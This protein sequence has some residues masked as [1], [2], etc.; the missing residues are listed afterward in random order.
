MK[1][2]VVYKKD[3]KVILQCPLSRKWTIPATIVSPTNHKDSYHVVTRDGTNRAFVRHRS[4]ISIDRAE[5]QA[6]IDTSNVLGAKDNFS[7]PPVIHN[8]IQEPGVM[9]KSNMPNLSPVSDNLNLTDNGLNSRQG[10]FLNTRSR[11]KSDI[12]REFHAVCRMCIE[13]LIRSSSALNL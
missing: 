10:V 9:Y 12:D 8:S 5:K 7:L 13:Y 11:K 4:M 2:S 3:D 1:G 6:V